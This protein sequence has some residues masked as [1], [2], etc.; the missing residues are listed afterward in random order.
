MPFRPREPGEGGH[1]NLR[2]RGS[3]QWLVLLDLRTLYISYASPHLTEHSRGPEEKILGFL[4]PVPK[5]RTNFDLPKATSIFRT[6]IVQNLGPVRTSIFGQ[7]EEAF[8][9]IA[10]GPNQGRSGEF[11]NPGVLKLGSLRG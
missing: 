11:G 1:D 2:P 6:E 9:S 8:G 7:T 3:V 5:I 10:R 4:R